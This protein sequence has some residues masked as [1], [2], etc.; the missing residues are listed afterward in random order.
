MFCPMCDEPMVYLGVEWDDFNLEKGTLAMCDRH[1]CS[2][3]GH[4]FREL[5]KFSLKLVSKDFSLVI[6]EEEG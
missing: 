6:D 5:T 2:Y 3:C 1:K 4:H